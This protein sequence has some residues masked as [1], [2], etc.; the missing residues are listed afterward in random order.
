MPLLWQ[1][2]W[3]RKQQPQTYS[4]VSLVLGGS[5][6]L[7]AQTLS[8]S[9]T[10][11]WT[12]NQI[13]NLSHI[14]NTTQSVVSS[15][16]PSSSSV[17]ARAP[18]AFRSACLFSVSWVLWG[19]L[20]GRDTFS[21]W[22]WVSNRTNLTVLEWQQG[23]GCWSVDARDSCRALNLALHLGQDTDPLLC[24]SFLFCRW[25]SHSTPHRSRGVS[26]WEVCRMADT[27]EL[28]LW[29]WLSSLLWFSSHNM[30][31]YSLIPRELVIKK[32][33]IFFLF[34]FAAKIM[35]YLCSAVAL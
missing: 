31:L 30:N 11:C 15:K 23:Q 18:Q 20:C 1:L 4:E 8:G 5:A 10:G 25:G 3:C 21:L 22:L 17:T 27:Q 35:L 14:S 12:S 33:N 6:F 7:D 34:L 32:N 9:S 19:L 24:L 28:L 2:L 29:C 26:I 13:K 16:Q